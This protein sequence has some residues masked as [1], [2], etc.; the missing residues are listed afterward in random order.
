M[1]IAIIEDNE[2]EALAL[3]AQVQSCAPKEL[4]LAGIDLYEKKTDMY[5]FFWTPSFEL[6]N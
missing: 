2:A 3:N 1:R 4:K 5:P 6:N